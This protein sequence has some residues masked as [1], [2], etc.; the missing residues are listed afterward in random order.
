MTKS[1]RVCLPSLSV[2]Y[3]DGTFFFRSFSTSSS[4]STFEL[5]TAFLARSLAVL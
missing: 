5:S 1:N 4:V 3:F 2:Q